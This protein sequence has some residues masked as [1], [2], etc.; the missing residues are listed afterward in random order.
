MSNTEH[1][2]V[3]NSYVRGW[4]TKMRNMMKMRVRMLTNK[5][6]HGKTRH[7]LMLN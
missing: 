4:S 3:V 6:K 1:H 5:Q 7:Y 2:A